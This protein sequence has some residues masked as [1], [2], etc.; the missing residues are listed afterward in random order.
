MNSGK[1]AKSR[2][3][4]LGRIL[5]FSLSCCL[6]AQAIIIRDSGDPLANTSAPTGQYA[7]SGWAYQGEYGDFLGTMI[8]PQYFITAQHIGVSA[9]P[10]FTSTAAFNGLAD[11][12]YT[13]D[14]AANGG[15]GFWN[16][17]GTDLRVFKIN[18]TF[19]T[20]APLYT[21]SS[22][23]GLEMV[24]FGRGGPRGAE[25]ELGGDLKGWYH[26]GPDGLSRWGA[27]TVDGI[28]GDYLRSDFD[29][30]LGQN[31]SSL[32]VG[33]SGGAV[34]VNDGGIWK[35]AGINYG[36]EKDFDTN[37]T[38]GDNSE[39][40]AALFDRGGFYQGSDGD[41]W[42][43]APDSAANSYASRISTHVTEIQNI[44]SVPEPGSLW[45]LTLGSLLVLR[46][47]RS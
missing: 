36:V 41:G 37:A 42:S 32:S 26:T 6:T 5:L 12:T 3:S 35:L 23:T 8:A 34:F 43:L 20:Y 27:N 25:V 29:D 4:Y 15:Q 1:S 13:I 9:S 45:L 46:R 19:S 33:D 10:T 16:I 22:E 28:V 11:V 14:S 30:V 38:P 7:D 18:E 17:A 47:R 24:V 2:H 31:E 39:F 21:G 44:A 40:E